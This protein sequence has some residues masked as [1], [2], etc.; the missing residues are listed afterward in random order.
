[1]DET[2]RRLLDHLYRTPSLSTAFTTLRP[3]YKAAQQ[4]DSTIELSDV[5]AYLR[6]QP[7][8]TLHR[9]VNHRFKRLKFVPCGWNTDFQADLAIMDRLKRHNNEHRY[10]LVVVELMSR[11]LYA[12]PLLNKSGPVVAAA[13]DR[14]FSSL[15]AP[16]WFLVTDKGTE[17]KNKQVQTL[18]REKFKIRWSTTHSNPK[19]KAAVAE[20]MVRTLK[21]RLY[22]Y[23]TDRGTQRWIDV[24][25]QL[26]SAI[27]ASPNKTLGMAPNDVNY[28]N[29]REL[30][31]RLYG[32]EHHAQPAHKPRFRLG[33]P[34]RMEKM[35]GAFDKGYLPNFTE[36]IFFIDYV[37][38]RNVTVNVYRLRDTDGDEIRG[39]FYENELCAADAS[40][41]SYRV[42]RV[43]GKRVNKETG[44]TEFRVRWKGFSKD[45]DSWIK[46]TDFQ[47]E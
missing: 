5:R 3:L 15:P 37:R 1:M 14:I 44:E 9:H 17:F 10:I 18:L 46:E 6:Q 42:E 35:K 32:E 22:R 7:T 11:R 40:N 41:I 21:E 8:Y 45:Y 24:L 4:K 25:P 30:W 47:K 31:Y 43:T 2:K 23:F 26:V 38:K 33:E 20:R 29:S 34:V 12:Q 27:N 36:E 39:W 13:F 19:V 16:A 28:K